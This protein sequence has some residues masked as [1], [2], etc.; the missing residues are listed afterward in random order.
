MEVNTLS[1]IL[2]AMVT[3]LTC[4]NCVQFFQIRSIRAKAAAEVD[5]TKIANLNT[6]IDGQTREIARLQERLTTSETRYNELYEKYNSLQEL[7]NSKL[8]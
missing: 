4:G 7:I 2:T 8:K 6:I 5:T 1:L 3:V